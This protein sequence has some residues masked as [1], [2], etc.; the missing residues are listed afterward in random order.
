MLLT[1]GNCAKIYCLNWLDD[2]LKT[3]NE[4]VR[5]LDLGCGEALNFINLLTKYSKLVSYVGVEPDKHACQLAR[6]N[7]RGLPATIIESSAYKLHSQL[8]GKFNLIFSFSALEHVYHRLAFLQTAK[9]YLAADGYFLIN[10]DSGHFH[11]GR[12]RL[13]N[14][15]GP[16]FAAF[17]LER[18]YQSLVR[19]SEF[20]RLIEFVGFSVRDDKF[21][22][23]PLKS[24]AKVIPPSEREEFSRR[25]LEYELWLNSAG[26]QYTDNLG[27]IFE[28]RNF[29]LQHKK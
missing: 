18:Y 7:L 17:G 16:L 21:F 10:Y 1:F 4:P 26:I 12:E 14:I 11:A 24:V 27:T 22:N 8:N 20:Q 3:R 23:T 2:Y 6:E 19:E 15:I 29:I 28:T 13:K 5:I 25:W 9:E